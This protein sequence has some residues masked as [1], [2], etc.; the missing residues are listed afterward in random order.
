MPIPSMIEAVL[1][2]QYRVLRTPLA[3]LEQHLPHHLEQGSAVYSVCRQVLITCDRTAAHLLHDG[4]VARAADRCEHHR[5]ADRESH[6]RNQCDRDLRN[7]AVLDEHRRRFLDRQY[8]AGH[9]SLPAQAKAADGS[10]AH[11]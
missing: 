5:S 11:R 3:M 10:D 9:T 2:T 6:A 8:R 4:A 1:R 7:A